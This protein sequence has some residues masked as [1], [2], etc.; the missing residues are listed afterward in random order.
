MSS[1][2]QNQVAIGLP[3]S[4]SRTV[5]P[6]S[7][8]DF[9][10]F[11]PSSTLNQLDPKFVSGTLQSE[12]LSDHTYRLLQYLDLTTNANAGQ[13]SAIDDFAKEILRVVGFEERGTLLRS[14]FAIPHHLR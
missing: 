14:R 4:C 6:L 2:L 1:D 7:S 9:F 3:T 13:E 10:G 11:E 8:R 5:N 12:G